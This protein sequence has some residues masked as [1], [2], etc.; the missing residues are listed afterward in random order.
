MAPSIPTQSAANTPET[1]TV[2]Q[3]NRMAKRLLESHFDYVWIE[4][5]LS[6]KERLV[7]DL[8]L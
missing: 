7:D 1:L 5:E 6:K 3:L 4:G 8:L 2:S